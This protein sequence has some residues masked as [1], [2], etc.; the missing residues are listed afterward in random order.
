MQSPQPLHGNRRKPLRL[1]YGGDGTVTVRSSCSLGHS[2][3]KSVCFCCRLRGHLNQ[4]AGRERGPK[5]KCWPIERQSHGHDAVATGLPQ[6]SCFIFVRFYGDCTGTVRQPCDSCAGP[7]DYPK[8]P[9]IS[10][11]DHLKSCVVST[12]SARPL[13]GAPAGFM[14]CNLRRSLRFSFNP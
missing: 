11:N 12:I 9:R 2:F 4:K 3:T 10:P 5:R 7:Y 14:R 1:P 8:D 6:G 13:Y